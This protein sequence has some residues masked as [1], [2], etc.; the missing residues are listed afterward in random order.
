MNVSNDDD[1]FKEFWFQ[2]ECSILLHPRFG[3]VN[4][5]DNAKFEL[6]YLEK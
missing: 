5:Y 1:A 4:D 6:N 2:P 3:K